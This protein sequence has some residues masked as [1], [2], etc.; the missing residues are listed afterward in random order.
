MESIYIKFKTKNNDNHER[1]P[2]VKRTVEDVFASIATKIIPKANPDFDKEIQNVQQWMLELDVESEI[3]SR[4]IGMDENE[5][6]IMI[7]P[8]NDNYGYWTDNNLKIEDFIGLFL[9][10]AISQEEFEKHWNEFEKR[11][12][13]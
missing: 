2:G 8:L 11:N 12:K 13:K 1:P 7:M 4:E 6:V 3:P 5:N 10:L 9:P